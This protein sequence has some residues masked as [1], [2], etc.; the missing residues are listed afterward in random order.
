VVE[1]MASLIGMTL[2]EKYTD[3]AEEAARIVRDIRAGTSQDGEWLTG[4]L[5][6]ILKPAADGGEAGNET[7]ADT[8]DPDAAASDEADA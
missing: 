7:P 4:K 6:I 3:V 5:E 1:P 2:P 8:P